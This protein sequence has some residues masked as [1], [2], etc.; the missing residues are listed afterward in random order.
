MR[1]IFIFIALFQ[2]ESFEP[3]TELTAIYRF[4]SYRATYRY[5]LWQQ[6]PFELAVGLTAKVRDALIRLEGNDLAPE[7]N[8]PWSCATHSYHDALDTP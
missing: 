5:Y 8:R 7:K 3:G 6:Q 4:N 1:F 2:G